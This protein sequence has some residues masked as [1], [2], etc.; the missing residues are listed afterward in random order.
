MGPDR[1]LPADYVRW[2]RTV[3]CTLDFYTWFRTYI[4]SDVDPRKDPIHIWWQGL[5]S[6]RGHFIKRRTKEW[7]QQ[8]ITQLTDN[9]PEVGYY[10][11]RTWYYIFRVDQP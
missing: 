3:P 10:F 5:L 8:L 7:Y 2:M 11:E 9:N 4:N 1:H 6:L